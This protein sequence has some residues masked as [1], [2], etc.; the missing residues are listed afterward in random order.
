M[1]TTS[2]V[3]LKVLQAVMMCLEKTEAMLPAKPEITFSKLLWLHFIRT[4]N[5]GFQAVALEILDYRVTAVTWNTVL[6]SNAVTSLAQLVGSDVYQDNVVVRPDVLYHP[7]D[8]VGHLDPDEVDP[9]E[10]SDGLV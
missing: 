3:S 8:C 10:P 5:A 7:V 2:L 9:V 6:A 4:K 1:E